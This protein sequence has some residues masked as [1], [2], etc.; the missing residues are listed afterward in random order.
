[1]VS[2]SHPPKPEIPEATLD[3]DGQVFHRVGGSTTHHRGCGGAQLRRRV[4]V[5][6]WETPGVDTPR[7]YGWLNE[8]NPNIPLEHTPGIPKPPNGRNSF[9][10]CWLRV[11]GMFQ[12]YVGKFLENRRFRGWLETTHIHEVDT[13]FFFPFWG[14][15]Y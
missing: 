4:V 2:K 10:K 8:E 12:G 13:M 5:T 7:F 15:E 9:I 11:W 3:A 1:M 6:W 14:N